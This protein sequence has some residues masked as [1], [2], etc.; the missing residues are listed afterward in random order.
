MGGDPRAPVGSRLA[1]RV[2]RARRPQRCTN[3][4]LRDLAEP[5]V[6]SRREKTLGRT[7]GRFFTV[8]KKH[9]CSNLKS[10]L[11]EGHRTRVARRRNTHLCHRQMHHNLTRNN[12][13][14]HMDCAGGHGLPRSPTVKSVKFCS[15]TLE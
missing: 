8:A 14:T 12:T 3:L 10:G 2:G 5:T 9:T 7:A 13:Y 11:A 6:Q 4:L 15:E 1:A